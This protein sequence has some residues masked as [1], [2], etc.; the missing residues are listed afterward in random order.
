MKKFLFIILFIVSAS[1][2]SKANNLIAYFNYAVM[3][4]P[5]KSPYL[6]VHLKI[7]VASL[8]L[9]PDGKGNYQS[10]ANVLVM[11]SKGK[12]IV[13][14]DK[15]VLNGPVQKDS[16]KSDL[17]LLDLR[18]SK[19]NDGEYLL[20]VTIH[21]RNDTLQKA[22]LSKLITVAF[23][24]V[25]ISFSDIILLDSVYS[26][27]QASDFT[28]LGYDMLPSVMPFYST[29]RQKLLFYTELYNS[30]KI[31]QDKEFQVNYYL[32]DAKGIVLE[33]FRKTKRKMP[34]LLISLYEGFNI[35]ELPD[36]EYQLVA[37]V[38]NENK[39][40]LASKSV[41]F[42]K[43]DKKNT[44][45]AFSQTPGIKFPGALSLKQIQDFMPYLS[46]I[47]NNY[48][49]DQINKLKQSKDTAAVRSW[50]LKFWEERNNES[51]EKAFTEYKALA[52]FV[53]KTYKSEYTKGYKTDR[54][55]MVLKYGKPD[56]IS[57]YYDEPAAYPYEIWQYYRLKAQ[58]N[59]KF[60]FYN[61][62]Q[63]DGDYML[64][65]SD[66]IG[67]VKNPQWKKFIY[68]RVNKDN[69]L[70]KNTSPTSPGNDLD[71]RYNE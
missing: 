68:R 14:F 1:S 11:I 44:S 19:L 13:Y 59:V 10:G 42:I 66:A 7:P 5:G 55:R 26:S 25:S 33:K 37:E 8:R 43:A 71:R 12:D 58:S 61:Q 49:Q 52:D 28:R 60:I 3:N 2:F 35:A 18:R 31:L 64:L 62:T 53:D 63:I 17:S 50:F 40:V 36:G 6:E 65:H 22:E 48:E 46:A 41:Y 51:P 34:E 23:P 54:G 24:Q 67:E 9:I 29:E 32:K 47:A 70:D 56:Y 27:A 45:N 15:Y 21:D 69:N 16:I 39:S 4:I 57:P 20:N 30:S 38:K